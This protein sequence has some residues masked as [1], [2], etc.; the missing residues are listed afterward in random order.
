M[1]NA[2]NRVCLLSLMNPHVMLVEY[3]M[4][5]RLFIFFNTLEKSRMDTRL[6]EI[7]AVRLLIN[8]SVIPVEWSLHLNT[9]VVFPL[10]AI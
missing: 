2:V 3:E 5:S 4:Y 10:F 1:L 6:S 9:G 8:Q 7:G